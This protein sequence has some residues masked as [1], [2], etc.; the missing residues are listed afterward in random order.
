MKLPRRKLLHLAAGAAALSAASR[1]AWAQAY[2]SRP[3]RLVVP[4]PPGG[5]F[6]TLARPWVEQVKAGNYD[7]NAVLRDWAEPLDIITPGI[8]IQSYPCCGSTHP[9]I[10]PMLDVVR[11]HRLTPETVAH[12]VSWTHPRRLAHTNRPSLRSA[13]DAKFSVQY[14]LARALVDGQVVLSFQRRRLSRR[15]GGGCDGPHRSGAASADV[16][17]RHRAFR[18]GG[19]GHDHRRTTLGEGGGQRARTHVG[20]AAVPVSPRGKVSRLT[21]GPSETLEPPPPDPGCL[22][23]SKP[24]RPVHQRPARDQRRPTWKKWER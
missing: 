19:D 8:A 21:D 23:R 2:P 13:L 15:A 9:A 22:A 14:C 7:G 11:A 20:T 12:V 1:I 17:R 4:F 24:W 5:A 18:C 16:I 6:A 3:I 10:Q